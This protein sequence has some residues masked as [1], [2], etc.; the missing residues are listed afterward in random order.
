MQEFKPVVFRIGEQT[1]GVDINYVCGI[2]NVINIVPIPNAN[3]H[4]K[5]IINLRGN[6][7]PLFSLRSKFNMEPR[8][9]DENTKFIITRVDGVFLAIE[10]D[11]VEEIQNVTNDMIQSIPKLVQ[12]EETNYAEKVLNVKGKLII[13]ID[14]CNL[15]NEQEMQ[16]ITDLIQDMRS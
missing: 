2:E 7:I 16:N 5:G 1:F 14:V 6:V 4:I 10:V 9:Y 3:R 8:P 11:G 13:I 15:L 12:S